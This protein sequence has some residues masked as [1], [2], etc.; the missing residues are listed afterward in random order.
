MPKFYFEDFSPGQVMEF[1]PR[2]VTREEIVDFAAQFDPQ[3]MHLDDEAAKATMLGGL[4]ASGWQICALA[5]RMA[6]D[7][8]VLETASMGAPGVDEV[9][10][11]R[12]LRPNDVLTLR[13]S[14]RDTRISKS[15]PSMGFV[16]MFYEMFN[17]DGVCIM[18]L[19]T[20]MMVAR[21]AA[22]A[23]ARD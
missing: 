11:M 16:V 12:P 9:R 3:P 2:R 19:Q 14:I 8:I 6:C 15:R 23:T 20:P 17:Q 22:A 1:G 5:M 7:G 13:I 21:R 18:T 4:G 10:W